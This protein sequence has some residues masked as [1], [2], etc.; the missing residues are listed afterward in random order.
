MLEQFSLFVFEIVGTVPAALDY[1]VTALK[2]DKR[3]KLYTLKLY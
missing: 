2:S 1:S 3:Y